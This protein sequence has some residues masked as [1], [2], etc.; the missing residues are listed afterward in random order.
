MKKIAIAALVI[1]AF[2]AVSPGLPS[3]QAASVE[4]QLLQM[5]VSQNSDVAA[6]RQLL[7][8]TQNVNQN[9]KKA[10]LELVAR[11]ALEKAGK[12]DLA[13]VAGAFSGSSDVKSALESAVQQEVAQRIDGKIGAYKD[14]LALL[15]QLFQSTSLSPQAAADNNSL[16]GAPANY[17]K[18]LNMKATAYSPGYRENG[19]WN[20]LTYLG[21]KIRN[22]V[23]AVDPAVIP[24]GSKLWV[25]GYG[26]AVAEDVGSAIK[27]NRIDLAYTDRNAALAYGIKPVKVYVLND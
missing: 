3:A 16:A 26:Q 13:Q 7:Q 24:L 11:T 2:A 21:G 8:V 4:E 12:G 10:L 17:R 6:I 15:S 5:A 1:M 18:V 27:G 14:G 9:D 22:G 25:E 20:D 19:R 23:V